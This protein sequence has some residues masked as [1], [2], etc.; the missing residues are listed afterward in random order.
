MSVT[1]F[2]PEAPT[3]QYIPYADDPTFVDTRPVFPFTD[4][5]LSNS[6]AVAILEVIAPFS[7][8]VSLCGSWDG[9]L[10]DRVIQNTLVALNMR[11]EALVTP[12]VVDGNFIFCGRDKDYVERRLHEMLYLLTTAKKHG[13]AVA[14]G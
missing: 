4:M 14:Y 11:V 6:N 13:Y 7:D 1:F 12:T 3:E 9:L 2:M 10:L 5:N 8:L